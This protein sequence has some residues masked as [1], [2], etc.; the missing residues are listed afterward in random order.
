MKKYLN[1]GFLILLY[2]IVLLLGSCT[3]KQG[4][5]AT[6]TSLPESIDTLKRIKVIDN[7]PYSEGAAFGSKQENVFRSY[8][9]NFAK[10]GYL[11]VLVE[12]HFDGEA[13][14]PA[15]IEDVKCAIRWLHTHATEYNVNPDRIEGYGH[16]TGAHLV[17]MTAMS[18][19]NPD[20]EGDGGWE[21]YSG[22]L[23]SVVGGSFSTEISPQV[24]K[25]GK[26]EWWSIGY[27]SGEAP[28]MLI[29]QGIDDPIVKI[30]QVDGF[31]KKMKVAGAEITYLRVDSTAH[32]VS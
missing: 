18:S 7:I 23:N 12:Y 30:N 1:P 19:E 17:L 24:I 9:L 10:Q 4:K 27:V 3:S 20:L 2:G 14:F 6:E 15:C 5:E 13:T 11:T 16:S 29:I 25:W 8:L 32:N 22:K 28:S 21:E 31:V 26:L